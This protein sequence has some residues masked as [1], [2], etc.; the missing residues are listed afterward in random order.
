MNKTT[1]NSPKDVNLRAQWAAATAAHLDA[2]SA[3]YPVIFVLPDDSRVV[4]AYSKTELHFS[5]N[6][7]VPKL[8]SSALDAGEFT[9]P[10]V[11]DAVRFVAEVESQRQKT[12]YPYLRFLGRQGAQL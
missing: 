10:T 3:D 4:A 12:D 1:Q 5:V 11:S 7:S 8:Q 2:F 9:A 6:R